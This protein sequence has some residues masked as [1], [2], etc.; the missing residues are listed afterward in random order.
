MNKK[1]L[2]TLEFNKVKALFEPHLLTE[3]GL[4]QLKELAPTDKGDKI[5]QAF[6]EMKEMQ[7]L[8][9]EHPHFSHF[10]NKDIAATCKRLEMGADLNIEE[11]LLLKRVIFASRELKNFYDNLENVRLTTWQI[12]LRNFTTSH[13]LQ[14]NLQAIN[15]AGFI[16]NFASEELAQNPS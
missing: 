13:I 1:I 15:E 11:F 5:R 4:E 3:Q 8:F 2:E 10:G 6:A 12:G 9:V 14:G 16:E 7:E